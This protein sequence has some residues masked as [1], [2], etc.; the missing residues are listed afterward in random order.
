M[1]LL[2]ADGFED[3]AEADYPASNSSISAG[4]GRRGGN[5]LTLNTQSVA[6]AFALPASPS[7]V[8]ASIA[9]SPNSRAGVFIGFN[10]AATVHVLIARLSDGAVIAYR[11]SASIELGRS[12]PGLIPDTGYTSIQTKVVIHDTTG[13]VEVRLN[14]S[15]TPVL[16]LT[17]VDTRNAGSGVITSV[18]LNLSGAGGIGSAGVYFDDLVAWDT[19]GSENND[20][21]G[22]LRVDSYLPTAD[23]DTVTL[24]TSSGSD[25][26]AL[27]D[28][29][30][31]SGTDYVQSGTP[32]NK[33]LYQLANMSHTPAAIH[34]V[35]VVGQLLKDDA[36]TREMALIL[37]SSGTESDSSNIAPSTSSQRFVRVWNTDPNG[38]ITWTK[39]AVDALQAGV[40]VTI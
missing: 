27:V 15:A 13:S 20:W 12:A 31:A 37:K 14:G 26:Y 36:G 21:L 32:G 38:S 34:A 22:D 29:V 1:A 28:E 16:T 5:A 3:S 19:T 35:L 4:N 23:G 24:T 7:T 40:K 6:E 10:E 11:G 39:S 33:D 30:P 2:I 18:V 17:N 9:V 8:F 25:H